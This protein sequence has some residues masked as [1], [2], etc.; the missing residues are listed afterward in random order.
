MLRLFS[1][2]RKTLINEGK[3]SRYVRYAVGE[4]LL[5][6]VG[7]LLALQVQTWNEERKTN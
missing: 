3:T 5:I 2:I 6:M 4:V 1:S 7:I